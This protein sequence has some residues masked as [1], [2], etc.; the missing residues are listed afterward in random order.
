[1]YAES[2]LTWKIHVYLENARQL[3]ET[4]MSIRPCSIPNGRT[5]CSSNLTWP[6]FYKTRRSLLSFISKCN[7]RDLKCFTKRVV[8]SCS[9]S[10]SSPS[11]ID[12]HFPTRWIH[13]CKGRST[14]YIWEC[15]IPPLIGNPYNWA[16]KP[17]L[18]GWWPSPI[19]GIYGNNGS[20]D[21]IA[22]MTPFGDLGHFCWVK[23]DHPNVRPY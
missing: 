22:H 20:L 21:P 17:L 23:F 13:M 9:C 12:V 5:W 2:I 1:M 11:Y 6:Q 7:Q 18:L 8:S 19:Y 15:V 14:P 4:Y 16:Y 3:T 10:G